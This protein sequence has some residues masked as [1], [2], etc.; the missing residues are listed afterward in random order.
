MVASAVCY[1]TLAVL[2]RLA[3]QQ[4]MRPLP[5]LAWRFAL[6]AVLLFAVQAAR[7][8]RSLAVEAR[9]VARFGVLA[10]AGYGFGSVCFFY[11]LKSAPASVVAVLL[12]AYPAIVTLLG[13]A[14]GGARPGRARWVA[15]SATFAGCALVSGVFGSGAVSPVGVALSLCAAAGYAVFTH[16]SHRWMGPHPRAVLMAYVF[17]FS[18]ALALAACAASG[19]SLSPAGWSSSAWLLLGA[20]VV[21]PT[22]AA[23]LL[24]LE[25]IH[26]L[27][28]PQAAVVSTLEPVFTIALAAGVLG[29]RLGL[30][31]AAGAALVVGGVLIGEMGE[32]STDGPAAV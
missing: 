16:L 7:S 22:A 27:G 29:E 6:V 4:G 10:V 28:A 5:L 3:Y 18:A 23:V 30:V 25:G 31:Q 15:L 13:W 2:T 26:G 12:Y 20:I 32:R 21:V 24:F 1:S 17:A 8:P 14:N 19:E 9:T 11:A